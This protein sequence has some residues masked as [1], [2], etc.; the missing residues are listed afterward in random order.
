MLKRT[1]VIVTLAGLAAACGQSIRESSQPVPASTTVAVRQLPAQAGGKAVFDAVCTSCHTVDPPAL[2]APPMSHVVR[3]YRSELDG[4]EAVVDRIA[5]WIAKP[6][7]GR[8]LLPAHAI[9]Q[10][11]VMPRLG[12]NANQANAVARYVLSL[13][14]SGAMGMGEG[15]MMRRGQGAMGQQAGQGMMMQGDQTGMGQ[16]QSMMMRHGQTGMGQQGQGMMMHR[17]MMQDSAGG[18]MGA[19]GEMCPMMQ[20]DSAQRPMMQHRHGGSTPP[21][22]GTV[23]IR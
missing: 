12:I 20:G 4:E 15:M 8:S 1:A 5:E 2:N 19:R 13:G 10:W 16:G 21:D 23:S 14:E 6:D 9:G 7:Q 18:G 11:G 3:H 22:T 17:G